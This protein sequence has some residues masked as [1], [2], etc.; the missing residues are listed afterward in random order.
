MKEMK[1]T[2]FTVAWI[3]SMVVG[4]I[5]CVTVIGAVIGVPLLIGMGKFNEARTMTD[6]ELVKNRG[7]LF[8]WGIFASIALAPTII[9]LIVLLIFVVMVNNYIKN[10]EE[11][12]TEETSKGF[13]QTVKEGS[14]KVW[15]GIK[16]VFKPKSDI[17]KQQE[18]LEKLNK[19]KEQNLITEE[20]YQQKRKQIL[21]IE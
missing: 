18:E 19:L 6:E 12:K 4:I 9:G 5:Y 13:G 15:N 17:E 1:N 7:S 20:E 2:Y 3:V 11:G 14:S 10:I 16:E 21:G 8:G